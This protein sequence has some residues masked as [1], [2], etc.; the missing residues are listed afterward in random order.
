MNVAGLFSGGKDSVYALYI[1][2]QYGWDVSHLIT[3]VPTN[4]E[5]W[6]FHAVNIHL[7]EQLAHA[8]NKPLITKKTPGEKET[9]L[10]DLKEILQHL[11]IDGVISGAIASEYQRTRIERVCSELGLKSFTPLWQRSESISF[12]L[13]EFCPES[14][15]CFCLRRLAFIDPV[16]PRFP[17]R[18]FLR[19]KCSRLFER[20]SGSSPYLSLC[21]VAFTAG[22]LR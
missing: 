11:D 21:W 17:R 15:W 10:G 1:A 3:L 22:I 8:L 5:S 2:E 9:E 16:L 13:R 12:L 20:R 19:L 4:P 14:S 6:M 7:T 18:H